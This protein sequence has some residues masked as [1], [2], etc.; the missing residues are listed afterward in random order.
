MATEII[1]PS[2]LGQE[3]NFAFTSKFTKLQKRMK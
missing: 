1:V 2:S 3:F